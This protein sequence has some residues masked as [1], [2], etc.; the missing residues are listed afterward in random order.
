MDTVTCRLL[1]FEVADGASN[2]AADETLLESA[3]AGV[4]SLRFYG[5]TEPTLSL[6]YFQPEASRRHDQRLS[7]LPY[8]RRP[9]GGDTLIHDHELT[10]AFAI[11]HGPPWQP[12][13]RRAISWLVQ[14]HSAIAAAL[15]TL[16]VNATV[17]ADPVQ[18]SAA[19]LCF[20]NITVGDVLIDHDKVVGS[21]QR[22]QRGALM[23]HGGILLE[24]SDWTPNLP[25]ILDL[26]GRRIDANN[27]A[28]AIGDA[29]SRATGCR[30]VPTDWT[31]AER[32]RREELVLL[33]YGQA[34]WN[35]K[36]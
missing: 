27:L 23:Q 35:D 19:Q 36:R 31:D 11:P 2:M 9:T 24:R 30:V 6:G 20:K 33:K 14:M 26:T 21:A 13:R 3:V 29:W 1:P 7:S 32:G 16:G 17:A 25:G 10:Y 28:T 22:R 5:W 18:A 12:I 15:A 4:A 34:A 8:V